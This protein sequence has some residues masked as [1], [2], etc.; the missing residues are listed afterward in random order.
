M[1][2]WSDQDHKTGV[3]DGTDG[4]DDLTL[5]ELLSFSQK[6]RRGMFVRVKVCRMG[7]Y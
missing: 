1:V 4:R 2:R 5:E 6:E 7:L 3:P